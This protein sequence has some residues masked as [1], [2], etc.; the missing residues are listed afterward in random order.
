MN[1]I[2]GFVQEYKTEKSL[3]A[4]KE[5][6]SPTAKVVRNGKIQV[7]NSMYLVQEI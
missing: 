4:L 3:E 1:A 5:L 2:L 7:I 6:A